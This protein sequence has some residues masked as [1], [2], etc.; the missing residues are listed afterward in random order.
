ML[1][2]DAVNT[3]ARLEAAADPG[4]VLVGPAVYASTKDVIDFAEIGRSR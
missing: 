1:T 3:A 2:G 4:H